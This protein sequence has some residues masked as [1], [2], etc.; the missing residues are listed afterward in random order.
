VNELKVGILALA[1]IA[2]VV[3]MSLKV[4]S[5][6]SGFGEYVGYRTIV[7]DASGI[8]PKTP[9]KVAGISAGR[10]KD[11]E[12]ADNNALITFE[13][14]EKVFI[15]KDSVLRIKTVGF[16]GDKYLEI[17]V[18]KSKDRLGL[19]GFIPAQEG[20]GMENLIRDASEVM[21]DVKV[22]VK[23]IRESLAPENRPPPLQKI[24]G[25]V[26]VLVENTKEATA[27]MKRLMNGNEEKLNNLIANLNKMSEDLAYQVDRDT[28]ENAI[29]K[30]NDILNNARTMMKDLQEIT[31][32]VKAGKG[33]VGK[34][35]VEEEI[36]DEVQQTLAGV[37]KLVGRVDQIR[38]E[39]SVFTGV[40]TVHGG[41]SDLA[42]VIYPS[43]ER[44]Y[45][46]G[47]AT[48]EFGVEREKE[49]TT[50][51]NGVSTTET[52]VERDK[53]T[54]RFNI[55]IGRNIQNWTLRGGLI[56]S[57]GGLG[58]DYHWNR[59]GTTLSFEVFDYRD[60]IGPNFRLILEAHIWNVLY[61]RIYGEDLAEDSR[62]ATLSAGLR[63][64]DEDL[65]GLIGF[66]L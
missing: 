4:T 39:L 43:P 60:D 48:S 59:L 11:I 46:L 55:Q 26:E 58:V 29:A 21:G 63:F 13:V 51:V 49:T 54:Y 57:T 5:N 27:T 33:T 24:L 9:I 23:N 28:P 56:E 22:I 15:P 47:L 1:T 66:F 2:S 62:S 41:Q 19:N 52:R 53:D 34:L 44:F 6:Q 14:L 31:A 10:I 17:V 25:D 32:D 3:Y 50:T 12:L 36:A 61:G 18:G 35:L 7:R 64:T 42:L 40:D 45:L 30:I 38:T 8:F 20:G 37:K 16:L 65:K